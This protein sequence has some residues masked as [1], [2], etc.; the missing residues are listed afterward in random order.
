MDR[1]NIVA[2]ERFQE[3]VDEAN[4]HNSPVHLK[5]TI[6]DDDQ[7]QQ[8]TVTVVSQSQVATTLGIKP[9]HLSPSTMVV[10]PKGPPAFNTE[11]EQKVARMAWEVIASWRVSL[12]Q[13]QVLAPANAQSG[14][15]RRLVLLSRRSEP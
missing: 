15:R 2:H 11:E 14:F 4:R 5:Q 6:L 1:L 3:I 7:L 12:R 9:Q 8:K 10:E 13:Y